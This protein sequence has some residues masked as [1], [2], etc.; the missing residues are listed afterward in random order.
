MSFDDPDRKW[1]ARPKST[2]ILIAAEG[3]D[4]WVE[5]IEERSRDTLLKFR[6]E[7]LSWTRQLKKYA[8]CYFL[9][10]PM[11]TLTLQ[12]ISFV[13]VSGPYM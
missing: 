11:T 1:I 5:K 10:K 13:N 2:G 4:M 8:T 12:Y 9:Q 6:I 3:F 7:V